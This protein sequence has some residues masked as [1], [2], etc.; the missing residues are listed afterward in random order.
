MRGYWL[1]KADSGGNVDAIL[2]INSGSST[3]KFAYF[4]GDAE[5]C[6][7]LFDGCAEGIGSDR[8]RLVVRDGMGRECEV[9]ERMFSTQSAAFE[10]VASRIA[11]LSPE[12]RVSGVGHRVVHGGRELTSHQRVTTK[13]IDTLQRDVH[14]A[15]LHMPASLELIRATER[16]YDGVPQFVCFDTAFHQTMPEAAYRYALPGRYAREG[17]RRYGFHG[18]S[19]ESIVRRLGIELRKSAVIAHLGS[20]SSITAVRDG[21]SIDTSMGLTPTGGISMGSR[22]GD[23]DPGVLLFLIRDDG[24]DVDSLEQMLNHECGLR[25]LAGTG[26]MRQIE[27]RAAAGD[28]DATL[29]VAIYCRSIAKTIAGYA[30]VMGGLEQLIFSGGIG[31][32]SARVREEVCAHLAWMGIELD[33]EKNGKD[34]STI[35]DKASWCEVRIVPSREEEQIAVHVRA[36]LQRELCEMSVA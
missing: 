9:L 6:D 18:L 30:A 10:Q 22:P 4:L 17:V 20:G 23:L 34:A 32:H 14:F 19:Y 26:D 1:V 33:A 11:A 29:A 21:C 13:V 16:L 25:A 35:S 8:G 5:G 15:P 3:L 24:L 31:E 2:A 7:R 36:M 28:A 27:R 12:L